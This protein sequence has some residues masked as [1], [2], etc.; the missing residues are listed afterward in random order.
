MDLPCLDF[1]TVHSKCKGFQYIKIQNKTTTA[2]KKNKQ[3]TINR[4]E[5]WSN[6]TDLPI[7][8]AL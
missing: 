2:R 5:F 3:K 1:G 7:G 4:I 6:C 8:L